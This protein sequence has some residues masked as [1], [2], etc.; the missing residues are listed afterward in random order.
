MLFNRETFF[1]LYR[2]T[3][4]PLKQDQVTGLNALLDAIEADD[5]VGDRRHVAYMLATT[6]HEV[7]DTWQPITERG[8]RNYFDKYEPGTRIG[9]NLGNTQPGDG[10]KYRGRGYVQLTGRP[11]YQKMSAVVGAN[12]VDNPDEALH[13]AHAYKILAHGFAKGAFTGKKITDYINETSCDYK[14]AR[15]CINALDQADKIS[16]YARSFE[17]ILAEAEEP[18]A[19]DATATDEDEDA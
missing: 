19:I 12:L 9:K 10:Y 16:A 1:T 13:P 11:N 4:G 18:D 17:R 7:A 8:A 15:R 14:N 2:Q 6:K 3:F 5:D